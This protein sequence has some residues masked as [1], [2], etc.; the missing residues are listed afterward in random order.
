MSLTL[1]IF[2]F[3][4][5]NDLNRNVISF[6]SFQSNQAKKFLAERSPTYMT[7]RTALRDLKSLTDILSRPILPRTPSWTP[8]PLNEGPNALSGNL[9][10]ASIQREREQVGGWEKYLKWEISNPLSIEDVP[11]L[12]NR[13]HGAFRKAVMHMRFFPEIW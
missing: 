4:T 7:A 12:R 3:S 13:L 10:K 11:T 8:C 1:F 5:H 9:L 2:L 6:F